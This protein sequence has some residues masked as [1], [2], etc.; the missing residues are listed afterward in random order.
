MILM[1]SACGI[2]LAG[3]AAI[4]GVSARA[5]GGDEAA[6]AKERAAAKP[7]MESIAN[8]LVRRLGERI[9]LEEGQEARVRAVVSKSYA[10]NEKKWERME[11]LRKELDS[12]GKE[13][14]AA[15]RDMYE[16]I[17]KTLTAEQKVLYD[18]MIVDMRREKPL[19]ERM[20]R[21]GKGPGPRRGGGIRGFGVDPRELPPELRERMR[22]GGD[23]PDAEFDADDESDIGEGD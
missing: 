23:S 1:K 9:E 14:G 12:T 22:S 17:R 6:A 20:G 7:S 13:L 10:A 4:L 2:L 8:D 5:S 19:L 16:D 11:A 15:I 18:E 3:A 21:R